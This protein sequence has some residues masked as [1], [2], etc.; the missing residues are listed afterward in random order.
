[1]SRIKAFKALLPRKDL[2]AKV[3]TRPFEDY[4]LGEAR[5]IADENPYSFL[6]LINPELDHHYLRGSRQELIYKKISENL[7]SFLENDYLKYVDQPSIFIYR[8]KNGINTHCGFWTLTCVIDNDEDVILKH[9]QTVARREKYLA[10]YLQQTGLDAIPVLITHHPN[11]T[12]K[13]YISKYTARTSDVSFTY[14]D[15]SLHQLWAL[16]DTSELK[17]IQ[18]AFET[19]NPVYLADGHHR[20]ASMSKMAKQKASLNPNHHADA[21]YNYFS[22]VYMDME[23]VLILQFHRLVK[24]LNGLTTADFLN[25]L[26]NYFDLEVVEQPLIP[27]SARTMGMYIDQQWYRLITKEFLFSG[28]PVDDLDV[29]ILHNYVLEPL[30]GIS[31][32]RT[33]ARISYVG[34]LLKTSDL[35]TQVDNQTYKAAFTLFPTSLEQLKSVADNYSVMPPKSTWVEPKFLVGLITNNFG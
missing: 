17:E 25:Q 24:D 8:I 13:Q 5:L 35:I 28:D 21:E 22:S 10:D 7:D 34:G 6:H 32:P 20:I 3:V 9:E 33:D 12:L 26:S 11:T 23:E 14:N 27:S 15:G 31:D 1:M 16:N 19:L 2:V 30:L 4:S 18:E 29:S